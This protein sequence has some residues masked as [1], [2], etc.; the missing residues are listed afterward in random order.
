MTPFVDIPL[1]ATYLG[2]ERCAFL[3]W[4]PK[5]RTV[6]VHLVHP[7]SKLVRLEP[8]SRGYFHAVVEGVRPGSR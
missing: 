1:G 8:G 7:E 2:E 6:H 4:A 5:A 3:V